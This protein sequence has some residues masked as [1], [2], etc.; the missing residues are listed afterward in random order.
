M[1]NSG[2]YR[3]PL[4]P[5]GPCQWR[6]P[7]SYRARHARRRPD[8]RRR[9]ADRADQ[10]RP[11]ARAG[12]QRGDLAR[13]PE[14]QPGHARYPLGLRLLHRRRCGDRSRGR[15]RDLARRRRLR[16]QLRR[17][18]AAVQPRAGATSRTGSGRWSSSSSATF[19][20]ASARADATQFDKTKLTRLMAEGRVVRRQPGIRFR[21][22]PA[23]HRGRRLPRRRRPG[24]RQRSRDHPRLRP[25]RHARLGQPLP[26]SPGRRPRARRGCGRGDGSARRPDHAS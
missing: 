5:A 4:E 8:L 21:P 26:R 16:H 24:P 25:V 11:G 13:H 15:R 22:R 3:G 20:P 19:R 12:R 1:S 23:R 9:Q 6:I 18:F 7:K 2:G 10:E 14:G 17:A